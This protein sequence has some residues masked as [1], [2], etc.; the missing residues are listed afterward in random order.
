M[1]RDAKKMLILTFIAFV[2]FGFVSVYLHSVELERQSVTFHLVAE[3]FERDLVEFENVTMCSI[4]VG[5]TFSGLNVN[6]FNFTYDTSVGRCDELKQFCGNSLYTHRL[7]N[8]SWDAREN[9]CVCLIK[10][11]NQTCKSAGGKA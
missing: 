1:E 10:Y 4:V 3:L 2:V 5:D 9:S 7:F 6:I 11:D 8:C